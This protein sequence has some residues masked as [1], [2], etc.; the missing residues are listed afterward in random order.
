V[1]AARR[2]TLAAAGAEWRQ[3]PSA[4]GGVMSVCADVTP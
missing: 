2:L 4:A 3:R 1:N